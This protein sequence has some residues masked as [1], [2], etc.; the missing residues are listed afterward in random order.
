MRNGAENRMLGPTGPGVY[1]LADL[2]RLFRASEPTIRKA[3][4]DGTLP[5]P[6]RLGMKK[7]WSR[8][9]IDAVLGVRTKPAVETAALR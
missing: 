2:C 4:A 6:I 9:A 7:V 8:A 3:V 1:T 5:N